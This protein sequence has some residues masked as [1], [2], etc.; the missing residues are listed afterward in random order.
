MERRARGILAGMGTHAGVLFDVDGT[1]LD[2]TYQHVVA[3]AQAF[4]DAGYDR[5]D[6]V[7]M[8]DIHR[9][10]GRSSEELVEELVGRADDA[11]VEGHSRR[12]DELRERL[13]PRVVRGGRELVVACADRGLRV[14]LATSGKGK[15]LDWMVPAIGAGDAL[16]GTTTA[17]RVEQ[18][19]PAPDLL[20]AAAEEH[21]LDLAR[22]AMIGDT[23]WDVEAARRLGI[24]G[25]GV[26]SGG[27][28]EAELREAGAAEVWANAEALLAGLDR[29]LLARLAGG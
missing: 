20:E 21:D 18:S 24:P 19:K 13:E 7:D 28:S 10:I 6:G 27:R 5:A 11:V 4:R 9:L 25:I 16:H 26:T 14:V 23:R 29:S 1:L 15:D 17:D 2:T 8:A 12:Y 22:T 3:W